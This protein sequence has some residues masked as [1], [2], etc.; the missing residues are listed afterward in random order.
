MRDDWAYEWYAY[1]SV[2]TPRPG[3]PAAG[4]PVMTDSATASTSIAATQVASGASHGMGGRP[5]A[6]AAADD[7]RDQSR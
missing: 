1:A 6:R 5:R 2:D 7:C 4:T 3:G